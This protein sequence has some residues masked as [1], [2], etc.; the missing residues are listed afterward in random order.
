[1]AIKKTYRVSIKGILVRRRQVLLLRKPDRSW[2]LPG[3]R[4][5]YGETAPVCL[6]RE[7]REETGL[8]A[9]VGEYAGCWVRHRRGKPDVFI[10]AFLCHGAAA[11]DR[12][13]LSDEHIDAGYFAA[14]EVEHLV[15]VEGCRQTILETLASRPRR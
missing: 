7:M 5:E 3:G 15:M 1:M 9:T 6:A 14:G 11:A 4:L 8:A 13:T 10:V 12:V 2:D